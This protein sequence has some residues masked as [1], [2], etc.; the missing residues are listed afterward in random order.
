MFDV[1]QLLAVLSVLASYS[2]SFVGNM[3][4]SAP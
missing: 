4:Y 3:E 1:V 2:Q